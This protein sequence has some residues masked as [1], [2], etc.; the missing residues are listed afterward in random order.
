MKA[1]RLTLDNFSY[2]RKGYGQYAFTYTSRTGKV[3][4]TTYSTDSELFDATFGQR[5]DAKMKDLLLLKRACLR[6]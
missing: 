4:K 5:S 6:G 1:N 2:E 3:K